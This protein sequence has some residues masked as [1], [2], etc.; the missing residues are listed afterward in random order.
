MKIHDF[1]FIEP[2]MEVF[3]QSTVYF[4]VGLGSVIDLLDFLGFLVKNR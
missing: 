2:M 1:T 3:I 4:Y